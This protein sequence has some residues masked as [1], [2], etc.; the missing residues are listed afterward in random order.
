M[1]VFL[2]DSTLAFPPVECAIEGGIL[3]VGGDLS[4]ERLLLAYRE[5]I[6]PWYSDGEPIIWWSPD[7]R[8]VLFPQELKVSKT[9]RQVIN[10]RIFDITFDADFSGVIARCAA[11]KRR[12]QRGTWIT[13]EMR[14]A[15]TALH[16]LGYAHSV[17][18]WKEG[19]LVGGLYGVSLGKIF[20]GESMFT[21]E[22]N[23]SKAA[24]VTLVRV[25]HSKGFKLI[26][27][28]VYTEHMERFGAREI[29]RSEYLK[30]LKECLRYETT[31][32]SWSNFL[33]ETHP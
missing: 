33:E 3:A 6:F 24:L 5:G 27:S 10:R 28:Q 15:Y 25:L 1:P 12:R 8:F 14:E 20:F 11:V 2:L 16:S 19:R 30:M 22:S 31:Q 26:D 32:G 7:P 21:L 23:A 13:D 4:P 9:T 17:E 29:P 18:S